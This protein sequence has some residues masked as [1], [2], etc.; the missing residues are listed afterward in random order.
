MPLNDLDPFLPVSPRLDPSKNPFVAQ[1]LAL[2]PLD[3][4][5]PFPVIQGAE[6]EPYVG[7]WRELFAELYPGRPA[8]KRLVLEVGCHYG[9]TLA[10]MAAD[11]PEVGF[12]GLDIT[13]KRVFKSAGAAKRMGLQNVMTALVN[14]RGIDR[15]FADGELDGTVVFFPD[16]WLK[17][18]QAKKRLVDDDFAE[19]LARKLAPGGFVWLKTDQEFYR[20][21]AREGFQKA[22]FEENEGVGAVARHALLGEK[23]YTSS[24]EQMFGARGQQ[25]FEYCGAVGSKLAPKL[26][27]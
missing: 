2:G 10:M 20:D 17:R 6:I 16:P 27:Q 19:V 23:L 11:H 14:A 5:R 13:F 3:G 25:W 8:P 22:R 24:F 12:I 26:T 18:Q 7:R 4:C 9:K 1:M 15:V 21:S